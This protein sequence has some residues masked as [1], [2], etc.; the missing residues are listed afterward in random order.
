MREKKKKE[1]TNRAIAPTHRFDVSSYRVIIEKQ[2]SLFQVEAKFPAGREARRVGG[3]HGY[4]ILH[5]SFFF[6]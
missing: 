3:G 5:V 1:E 4:I 6:F 2:K